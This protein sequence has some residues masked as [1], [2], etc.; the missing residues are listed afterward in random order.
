VVDEKNLI[1]A[2]KLMH[3]HEF[4]PSASESEPAPLVTTETT[5]AIS[6]VVESDTGKPVNGAKVRA[7][8]AIWSPG[9]E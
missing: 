5:V 4:Q 6:G 2:R 3:F 8:G 7:V 1:G 9:D